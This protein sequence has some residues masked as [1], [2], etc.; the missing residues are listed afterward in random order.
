MSANPVTVQS[1]STLSDITGAY[2]IAHWETVV[3]ELKAGAGVLVRG[4]V[5]SAVAADAGKLSLTV[6]GSEATA[7]GVLLD[8][9][10]D[11]AAA[12]STGTCTASVAR[13]GSFRGAALHTGTGADPVVLTK[14]LRLLGI[15]VEGALAPAGVLAEGDAQP[16]AADAPPAAS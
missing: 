16:A 4:S 12:N 15:F 3:A 2:D 9:Y 1:P 13:A 6:A 5:L 8:A 10:V 11:T 7:F 14:Q